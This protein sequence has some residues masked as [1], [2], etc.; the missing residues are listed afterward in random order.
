MG[1]NVKIVSK[2]SLLF[3]LLIFANSGILRAQESFPATDQ[4]VTVNLTPEE[5]AWLEEH[6]EITLGYTADLEPEIIVKADGSLFG[7][8]C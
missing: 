8:A 6:P 3:L 1:V 2:T 4:E 5:R 7:N